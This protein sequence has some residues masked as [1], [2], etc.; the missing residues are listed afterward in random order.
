MRLT[1]L[2]QVI[3]SS[4]A[5]LRQAMAVVSEF[6]HEETPGCGCIAPL[7]VLFESSSSPF[8]TRPHLKC[9]ALAYAQEPDLRS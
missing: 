4:S 7:Q 8:D 5:R 3:R 2:A 1:R 9:C 6:F